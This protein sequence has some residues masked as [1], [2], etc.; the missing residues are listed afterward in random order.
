M[1]P[2]DH[3]KFSALLR[4]VYSF[5]RQDLSD[6]ALSV[7]WEAMRPFDFA[8][9]KDALNRHAVNPDNG[10]F[11][12]KPAD[13]VKLLR[14]ST[15]DGALVAWA[16]VDRAMR[17]V[18]TYAS[19]VFDDP[20]IH[21]VVADMGGWVLLGYAVEDEWPFKAKEFENRYRGYRSRSEFEYPRQLV[22]M[23]EH[24]NARAGFAGQHRVVMI[25]D[26]SECQRVLRGGT[27]APLLGMK[28]VSQVD[29]AGLI[30]R[31]QESPKRIREQTA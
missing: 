21:R 8:A 25:G 2:A 31:A 5:Y 19:V 22:G 16:K 6:F 28:Q 1:Q 12:P 3:E 17:S 26:E 23:E 18:G 11:L 20:I 15:Q 24:E 30:E 27:T 7:W 13:V 10:Q 4:G 14:G 9:V 29:V